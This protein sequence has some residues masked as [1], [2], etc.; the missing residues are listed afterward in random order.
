MG[1]YRIVN[2]VGFSMSGL[3]IAFALIFLFPPSSREVQAA[4]TTK[5]L[6]LQTTSITTTIYLPVVMGIFNPTLPPTGPLPPVQVAPPNGAILD[7]ISPSFSINNSAIGQ[8]AQANLQYAPVPDFTSGASEFGFGVFHGVVTAPLFWNLNEGTTYY[9]RVR[10]SLDGVNWGEWSEVWSFITA[11]GGTLPGAPTLISPTNQSTVSSL[12]PTLTWSLV[13]G[14]TNYAITI[15]GWTWF[16]TL[17]ESPV[18]F[19]LDLN[20]T[21]RWSVSARN[22]YG[23]GA[24]SNEWAFTT[25]FAQNTVN[26]NDANTTGLFYDFQGAMVTLHTFSDS[27]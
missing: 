17:N 3:L 10:S 24:Q 27:H 9:W 22:G 13:S 25:P 5:G 26:G 21:Y 6:A 4:S 8:S 19:D 16:S 2:V 7:T 1:N 23:W 14:A 20:A 18:I 15:G 11:S 12:R